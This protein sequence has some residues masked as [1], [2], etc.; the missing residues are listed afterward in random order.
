MLQLL[1]WKE[2]Q[3]RMIYSLGSFQILK[4][5]KL[6]ERESK[7]KQTERKK[8]ERERMKRKLLP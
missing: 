6:K 7:E 5:K 2:M 1:F 4:K 8:S 3:M